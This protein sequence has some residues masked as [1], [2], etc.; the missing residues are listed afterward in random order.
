MQIYKTAI[1][2]LAVLSVLSIFYTQRNKDPLLFL[3][4][5]TNTEAESICNAKPGLPQ[6]IAAC[7]IATIYGV[8]ETNIVWKEFEIEIIETIDDIQKTASK[9][10]FIERIEIDGGEIKIDWVFYGG[11]LNATGG[12]AVFTLQSPISVILLAGF[13]IS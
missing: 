7:I 6:E 4:E 8:E 10:L 1:P 3:K 13:W 2:L 11:L 5:P 12:R 9:E